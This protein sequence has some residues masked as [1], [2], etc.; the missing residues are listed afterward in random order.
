[1]KQ[2]LLKAYV[3]PLDL[4][5]LSHP[6]NTDNFPVMVTNLGDAAAEEESKPHLKVRSSLSHWAE[7][8]KGLG[9]MKIY[10]IPCRKKKKSTKHKPGLFTDTQTHRKVTF[11]P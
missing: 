6:H 9:Y 1:M 3:F 2:R 5:S 4:R 10:L 11:S 7:R 8:G